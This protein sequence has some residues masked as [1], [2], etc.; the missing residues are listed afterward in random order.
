[1][2]GA[3]SMFRIHMKETPPANYRD[4]YPSAME[5]SMRQ[6]FLEHMLENGILLVN[7]C[8]GMLSTP[9]TSI[10]IDTLAEVAVAGFKR[11]KDKIK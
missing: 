2:T 3:G 6:A 1:V 7:T 4:A 8:T 5:K 11:I 9:M 10:E